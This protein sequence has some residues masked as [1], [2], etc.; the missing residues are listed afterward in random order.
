MKKFGIV[1]LTSVPSMA[2]AFDYPKLSNPTQQ[3]FLELYLEKSND[4]VK[5]DLFALSTKQEW[6]CPISQKE[7]NRL[8]NLLL[9]KPLAIEDKS[10]TRKDVD[11]TPSK[12]T[13]IINKNVQ[14]I[15]MKAECVNGKIMGK[16]RN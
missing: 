5:E 9:S 13:I 7:Q 8:A 11:N 16:V 2:F 12:E 10:N 1:I 4:L 15:P 6:P 14:F 3:K